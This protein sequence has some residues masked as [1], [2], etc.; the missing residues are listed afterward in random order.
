MQLHTLQ[1]THPLKSA[2]PRVGRGGKRGSYSG[3]GIKGQK[4]HGGR[5]IKP[6]ISDLIIRLP[7]LR[8]FK[9]KPR[10]PSPL[11]V[12]VGDLIK[13]DG[14]Q[15][16]PDTLVKAHLINPTALRR[17]HGAVK[18]LGNGEVARALIIERVIVSQLAADKIKAAKG[19]IR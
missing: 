15:I 11:V 16:T 1:P 5:K 13:V 9:N 12:N 3:R 17:S 6:A 2:Q 4:A 8:G 19:T 18:I 14:D 7:K 10:R